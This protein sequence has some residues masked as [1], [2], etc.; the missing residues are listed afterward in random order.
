M[1]WNVYLNGRIIDS[2]FYDKDCDA[3]YVKRTLVNH[4]GYNPGIIVRKAR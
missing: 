2:V 1:F 3:W 4:D